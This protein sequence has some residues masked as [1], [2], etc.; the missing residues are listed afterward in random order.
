VMD[1]LGHHQIP[2]PEPPRPHRLPR[3]RWPLVTQSSHGADH[4]RAAGRRPR[5]DFAQAVGR[6]YH[7]NLEVCSLTVSSPPAAPGR[8]WSIGIRRPRR[9]SARAISRLPG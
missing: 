3:R 4:E 8:G 5:D 7:A 9:T 2:P 1:R 6:A